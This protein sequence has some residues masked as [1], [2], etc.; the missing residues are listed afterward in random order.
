[1]LPIFQT[2]V[3]RDEIFSGELREEIFAARL[4]DV[5]EDRAEAVYQ[6]PATFF[7]NTYP[8]SGLRLLLNEALGRLTGTQ[9]SNN[10]I[11]RLE[12]AFGG[13]KT[14]NLIALYHAARGMIPETFVAA[15]LIP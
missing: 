13:G 7:D 3:P 2:C 8:T 4:R 14:H 9:S 10:A 6:D 12:T 15:D 5:I 1:M 11:I